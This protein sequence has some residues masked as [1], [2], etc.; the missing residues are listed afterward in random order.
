MKPHFVQKPIPDAF[1]LQYMEDSD[2]N[3]DEDEISNIIKRGNNGQPDYDDLEKTA[4]AREDDDDSAEWLRREQ[5][6]LDRNGKDKS[7]TEPTSRDSQWQKLVF[8][9]E[10]QVAALKRELE[11][12]TNALREVQ[13]SL[14]ES[15]L[16]K[17]AA[18]HRVLQLAKKLRCA[19]LALQSEK[20]ECRKLRAEVE[21][22]RGAEKPVQD[23]ANTKGPASAD[24][25]A[26]LNSRLNA[27]SQKYQDEKLQSQTLKS[28]VSQ[29]QQILQQEVGDDAKLSQAINQ[30]QSDGTGWRGRAQQIVQL[31]QRVLQLEQA[32]KRAGSASGGEECAF[33]PDSTD[34]CSAVSFRESHRTALRQTQKERRQ[35]SERLQ[36]SLDAAM[37]LNGKLKA[38][39]GAAQLRITMLENSAK[40]TKSKIH[41][42]VQKT[43]H[44]DE[45][46]QL[47]QQELDNLSTEKNQVSVQL[48]N[49]HRRSASAQ[50][51]DSRLQP[52][53]EQSAAIRQYQDMVTSLKLQLDAAERTIANL[54]HSVS[55]KSGIGS[56]SPTQPQ[57]R[58]PLSTGAGSDERQL[59][60]TIE[61]LQSDLE[62]T[63]IL[64]QNAQ[65][66][67]KTQAYEYEQII[68]KL[69]G[70]N[71][72]CHD[73]KTKRGG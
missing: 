14:D 72:S 58:L 20:S 28:K 26:K 66:E 23:T 22:F 9:K 48:E 53:F 69:Q 46:I 56:A 17:P 55:K 64:L 25:I 16:K 12:S 61:D 50:S 13:V 38:K 70:I 67:K 1:S 11:Q 57:T 71:S 10:K 21:R 18:H 68:A 15:G 34:S 62:S 65:N 40:E 24:E 19:T 29:L 39:I 4:L 27:L 30:K 43:Q 45:Y 59:Q 73:I 3:R 35:E 6:E 33:A 32:V 7:M 44:D 54:E 31:K 41:V 37:E 52:S 42:L 2:D 49:A 8:E 60:E 47:L 63:R 51:V 5:R 36:Q